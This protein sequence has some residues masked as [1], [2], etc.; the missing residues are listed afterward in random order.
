MCS[1]KIYVLNCLDYRYDFIL[2]YITDFY[3]L[4]PK[5]FCLKWNFTYNGILQINL[6]I[7][8]NFILVYK[9]ITLAHTF[10]VYAY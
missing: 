3:I 1:N 4:V 8:L 10:F 6:L 7:L 5:I 9:N 2:N